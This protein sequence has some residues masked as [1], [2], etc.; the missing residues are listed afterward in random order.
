MYNKATFKINLSVCFVQMLLSLL[1]L[2]VITN[3]AV[4]LLEGTLAYDGCLPCGETPQI[5]TKNIHKEK[6]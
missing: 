1:L 6:C 2:I 4:K 3:L 5:P